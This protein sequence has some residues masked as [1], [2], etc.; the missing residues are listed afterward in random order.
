MAISEDFYVPSVEQSTITVSS[1]EDNDE[2]EE[3]KLEHVILELKPQVEKS[4]RFSAFELMIEL[5]SKFTIEDVSSDGNCFY[6]AV[7]SALGATEKEQHHV[8]REAGCRFLLDNIDIKHITGR[9]YNP[10]CQGLIENTN[11]YIKKYLLLAYLIR[12]DS[13]FDI[14]AQLDR[15]T[16]GYN[17]KK[18]TVTKYKP[19]ELYN[20][21]NKKLLAEVLLTTENYYSARIEANSNKV[22][23][24]EKVSIAV[25]IELRMS[26]FLTPKPNLKNKQPIIFHTVA[27]V[28]ESMHFGVIAITVD[29]TV[30]SN[31]KKGS[32]YICDGS[33]LVR[34]SDE[35]HKNSQGYLEAQIS[36]S[37]YYFSLI[38]KFTRK[39]SFYLIFWDFLF[40]NW[41]S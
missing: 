33:I 22:S 35:Q 2:I 19:Y 30:N 7:L 11:K 8:L 39:N 31:L 21:K 28:Q 6:H 18:H 38:F 32:L 10:K 13:L 27:T 15:I 17:Q 4:K 34:L 26:S 12:E 3:V 23:I 41:T 37:F 25:A 16:A 29:C 24:G 40:T 14:Q 20:S 36:R 5:T 9:P 1:G